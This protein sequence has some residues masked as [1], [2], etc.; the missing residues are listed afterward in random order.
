M[1][2]VKISRSKVGLI[3]GNLGVLLYSFWG[4]YAQSLNSHLDH[5]HL[6]RCGVDRRHQPHLDL[7]C[8]DGSPLLAQSM[9]GH[10]ASIDQRHVCLHLAFF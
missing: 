7:Q 8:G 1:D 4:F 2:G 6:Q 10:V 3:S 9:L 5:P